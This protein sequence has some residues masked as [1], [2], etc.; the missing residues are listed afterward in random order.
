MNLPHLAQRLFNTPLALHPSKAEV[1][2]ASVMDRFGI[3]KIESSLAMDDDWYGYDDNRGRESRS[4]PGYDNVLGVA[5]IPICGTLVQKLGI[6]TGRAWTRDPKA[7][8]AAVLR[9]IAASF[10]RS[11]NDALALLRGAFPKTATIMLTEWEKTLGLP[12][13]CSIGEV[14]TIAKRQSAIVSKLISTGGQSK[15]YFI[16]IA[17]A[18]GYTISI[19]EYRQARAGLSVCGDGLNGDDWPFVWLVEAEDT[20]IT[21]ARAGLSY[22]GDPLRSWGN[23]QLE[24]RI[25]A[26]A[27]SYTLVK[28]GYIYFGFND[29]GVYEVT[30]EFARIFDIASGYV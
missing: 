5:V 25:N 27:P 2:M 29:E 17:A 8:Q 7:V 21:Y 1:I 28:F 20:T 18:M 30:P 24:C 12:D 23:R 15:S 3:S 13:D 16:S 14:D 9:A 6:P 10:Q 11:D 26:L 19:K 4:D 22:C